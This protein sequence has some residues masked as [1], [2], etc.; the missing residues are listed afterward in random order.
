MEEN[1]EDLPS[2]KPLDVENDIACLLG[3]PG[4]EV[5]VGEAVAE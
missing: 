5:L 2:V 4:L 3:D 1:I